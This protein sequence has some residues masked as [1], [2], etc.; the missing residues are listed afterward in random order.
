[1]SKPLPGGFLLVIEGIDGAGKSTQADLVAGSLESRGLDVVRTSEPTDGPWGRKIR[2]S[3]ATGR[4]SPEDEL[5]AFIEDRRQ[6]VAELIH[7]SVGAGKIV[8]TDR[9]YFS[10]V[11]YQGALGFDPEELLQR[12]ESFAVEPDLLVVIDIPP[13]AGLARV[14]SRDG[15]ANEFE[16]LSQLT[17]SRE[18]FK[19]LKKPYKVEINGQCPMEDLRDQIL[20]EF[21]C[22]AM[23]RL[24]DRLDLNPHDR[25]AASLR[26]HGADSA[27]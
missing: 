10:T 4:M 9:Y 24:R 26:L 12:N 19:A 11:A 21:G 14:G 18:I 5:H 15:V 22:A 20:F 13:Q 1:M 17:R 7:P 23:A 16:T 27:R 8:V 3:A 2:A 25:L 6:H